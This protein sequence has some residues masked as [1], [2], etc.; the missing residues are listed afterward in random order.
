MANPLRILHELAEL[1]PLSEIGDPLEAEGVRKFVEPFEALHAAIER[2]RSAALVRL[3][4][5]GLYP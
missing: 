3:S 5:P 1:V 4:P 2:K